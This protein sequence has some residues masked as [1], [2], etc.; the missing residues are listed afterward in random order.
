MFVDVCGIILSSGDEA[1][2]E[3]NNC[4]AGSAQFDEFLEEQG[5][6]CQIF[7]LSQA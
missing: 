7:V 2:S 4:R 1:G 5:E 3:W 6:L